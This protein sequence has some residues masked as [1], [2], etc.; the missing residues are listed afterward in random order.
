MRHVGELI[1]ARRR[2]LGLTLGELA[3][4]AACAKG[5]LSQIENNRRRR[6]PSAEMLGRLERALALGE[7]DLV[8]YRRWADTPAEVR[9]RVR[10]L[11]R[12]DERDRRLAQ[13]LART[14]IDPDKLDDLDPSGALRSLIES[15]PAEAEAGVETGWGGGSAVG[16]AGEEARRPRWRT[17]PAQPPEEGPVGG[18]EGGGGRGVEGGVVGRVGGG[19]G[20][21]GG[22]GAGVVGGV[23]GGV[24]RAPIVNG[25]GSAWPRVFGVDGLPKRDPRAE[26]VSAPM[27][28]DP[29]AFAVRVPDDSMAPA[30]RRGDLVVCSPRAVARAGVDCFVRLGP[31][32]PGAI[33]RLTFATV[34]GDAEERVGVDPLNGR[35]KAFVL[36]RSEAGQLCPALCVLRRLM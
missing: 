25:R 18:S 28:D 6:P 9:D 21:G 31:D 5:Y 19:V 30:F 32:G 24:G 8:R 23:G 12:L 29:E 7:N 20:D 34:L 1:R 35:Y 11:E 10:R 13:L 15:L 22:V 16:A 4:R 14:P 27:I 26:C 33:R 36:R 17:A 2:E 3:V